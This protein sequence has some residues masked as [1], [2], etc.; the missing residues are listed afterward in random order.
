MDATCI[1]L[2]SLREVIEVVDATPLA[3]A[4]HL[5]KFNADEKNKKKKSQM[6]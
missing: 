5:R 2:F 1:A 3:K 4:H 6:E